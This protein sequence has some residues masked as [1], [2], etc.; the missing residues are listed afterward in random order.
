MT[1]VC[2]NGVHKREEEALP[3]W[4]KRLFPRVKVRTN[5]RNNVDLSRVDEGADTR[6][7]ADTEEHLDVKHRSFTRRLGHA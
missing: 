2:M 1:T 7:A 5:R 6:L 3:G 4:R